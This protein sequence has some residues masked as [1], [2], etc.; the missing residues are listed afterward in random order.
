MSKFTQPQIAT[1]VA[2]EAVRASGEFNMW[3]QRARLAT[4]LTHDEYNFVRENFNAL[5]EAATV[6]GEA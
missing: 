4:G 3:D 1:W 5:K 2:Y 6:M